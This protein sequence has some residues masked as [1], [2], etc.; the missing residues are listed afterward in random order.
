MSSMK[1]LAAQVL[2]DDGVARI[3]ALTSAGFPDVGPSRGQS[4]DRQARRPAQAKK[5]GARRSLQAGSNPDAASGKRCPDLTICRDFGFGTVR[6]VLRR[7]LTPQSRILLC[8]DEV[9]PSVRM[10]HR[11]VLAGVDAVLVHSDALAR[12]IHALGVPASRIVLSGSRDDF[13]LFDCSARSRASGDLQIVHVGDLEPEAGVADFLLCVAAW[14]ERN[15]QRRVGVRWCGEGCLRGVLEA[16]PLPPNVQQSFP[17]RITRSELAATFL[18]CDMLAL[19]ALADPWDDVVPEALTAQLPVLGSMQ[20]RTVAD[21]VVHGTTGW[22]FDP[23]ENGAMA[24]TVEL[25]LNTSPDELDWMRA[26]AA[27][28]PKPSLPS[29]N[30][31]IWHAMRLEGAG[32]NLDPASLGLAR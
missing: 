28:R 31:R 4:W 22:V 3:H 5:F 11:V 12:A 26:C 2:G 25:A 19:P 14:A 18:D 6:A 13:S 32:P 16:Q 1:Q 30:E 29:L 27:E 23:F 8:I 21:L 9:P 24:R 17:G 7:R 20:S 15:P 10:A